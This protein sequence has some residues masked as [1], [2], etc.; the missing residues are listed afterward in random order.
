MYSIKTMS[1][2]E[3]ILHLG[4]L[5]QEELVEL[6]NHD[7]TVLATALIYSL[8][9]LIASSYGPYEDIDI[10][11][12][13]QEAA[14]FAIQITNGVKLVVLEDKITNRNTTLH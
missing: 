7:N 5:P 14:T 6:S 10:E 3:K 13:V 8:S 11:S 12:I 1:D 4:Q 2:K 9:E